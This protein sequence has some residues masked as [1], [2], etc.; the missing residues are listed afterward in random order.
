MR[1]MVSRY[2]YRTKPAGLGIFWLTENA[3]VMAQ[4]AGRMPAGIPDSPPN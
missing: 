1:E 3:I 4:D 2:L